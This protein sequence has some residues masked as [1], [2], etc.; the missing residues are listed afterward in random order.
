M[1]VFKNIYGTKE[2]RRESKR[3]YVEIRDHRGTVRRIPGFTD[4]KLTA[5]FGRRLE[6]LIGMRVLNQTPSPDL[7]AWI[8]QLPTETRN[9]LAKLDILDGQTASGSK[10]LA[11]HVA[12]WHRSI[13]DAGRT[14]KYANLQRARV[15]HVTDGC[16]FMFFSDIDAARI[17]RYLADCRADRTQNMSARTSNGHLQ[18]VKQFCRWMVREHRASV[19]AVMHLGGVNV[20]I[21][22]RLERRELVD[23]E[24]RLLL[25]SARSGDPF[26]GLTG[27]QRFTLYAT[28]LGS[29]LRASELASLTPS[30]FNLK[31][32]PPTV[33]INAADEKS[34]RGDVSPLPADLVAILSPWVADMPSDAHL[35]PG[36]WAEH[37]RGSRFIRRDLESAGVPYRDAD[38]KQADFHA[39]RHTYLSRLGRSG[40]SPKVMQRL[41][42]HTTVEL[43][44]GRYTHAGL[45][46]LSSA[47][48]A[49]PPLPI[50][51]DGQQTILQATGT[52][53]VDAPPKSLP[54]CLP[55]SGAFEGVSVHFPASNVDE[56]SPDGM[57][58]TPAKQGKFV[59]DGKRRRPD[60]NRGWRIC[61]PLP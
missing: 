19:S 15:R 39:L 20:R 31:A 10:P 46:D 5:E 52:Y 16:G 37:A 9:R 57:R 58:T 24:I 30:H 56:G 38:G 47:V 36:V 8:E 29:G 18:A 11:Q 6:R 33:C 51:G 4:R 1:R 45:Y 42:R 40:A 7:A 61:N 53:A 26:C 44:L 12:D 22:R 35:W 23:D 60:S 28:A 21:D 2:Q 59:I 17:Q 49:L 55:E 13:L 3:W 27:W 14:A 32:E 41:A 54:E 48:D 34:R 43:T 25:D 50:T